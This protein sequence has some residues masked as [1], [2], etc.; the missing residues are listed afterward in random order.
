MKQKK[1]HILLFLGIMIPLFGCKPESRELPKIPIE[2]F[3]RNPLKT[4]FHLSP[5][6]QYIS[7]LKPYKQRLNLFVQKIGSS[8]T[9]QITK[10]VD[11]DIH[12]Y[13]WINKDRIVFLKDKNGDEKYKL[14]VVKVDGTELKQLTP[15]GDTIVFL[16]DILKDRP[17]E[18]L[19]AINER[20]HSVFD[21]YKINII[22]GGKILVAEN[23]GNVTEWLTDHKGKLRIAIST[24]GVNHGIMFRK[25]ED[26]DF[27]LVYA[28]NFKEIL[29]PI[30]F[31]FDNKNVYM[32]SNIKR[33]RIALI[34]YDLE[35]NEELK[36]I[37]E[38]PEVDIEYVDYS[39]KRKVITDI[40]FITWKREYVFFDDDKENLFRKL[41]TKLSG[42][43]I[44]IA[45]MS[46]DE[47][48]ILVKTYSDKSLGSYYF[49]NIENEELIK[50]ADVSP[51]LK[52]E[53]LADMKP[54]WYKSRDGL[55]INGYLTL[56]VKKEAKNLPVV[57]NPHG[58]PWTRDIWGFNNEVQFFANR[59]FAVLQVNYR[60][61][62]GYGLDFMEAGFGEW[63][64]NMQNDITDG[65][66]WL[67]K[68]GIADPNKIG[69]YGFSFGGFC[70]L[71]GAAFTPN[72]YQC[73]ASLSGIADVIN[74]LN[75]IPPYWL[76]FREMLNEMVGDPEKDKEKLVKYSPYYNVDSIKIPLL[77]A[78][79]VN[80]D[81]VDASMV[82]SMVQKLK[83]N[84][85]PVDYILKDNEGHYFRNEENRVEFYQ[86]LEKFLQK[87]L[88]EKSKYLK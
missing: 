19:V 5:D 82:T 84:S 57:I 72:L 48:K 55:T 46:D 25:N 29:A 16:I 58:G 51:W 12:N 2:D 85:V 15:D 53:Y 10:Y 38:H 67:V 6:G 50:L 8:D 79:G 24:D 23:P 64:R 60:G 21:V 30:F 56:P 20:N 52:E 3:F 65:A 13:R 35:K 68:Q 49:F 37:Y 83:K 44:T 33:D 36:T 32:L 42:K 69:I 76:P 66:N 39:K 70:A 54:I 87:H 31:T 59:G 43:E 41:Q 26:E 11:R 74:F 62:S 27:K 80:D 75:T 47:K 17:D 45:S 81:R 14:F 61:S 86:A 63:G 18:I 7:Y 71:A 78:Q 9:V 77:I 40:S 34:E 28:T 4:N 73:A 88:K 1:I 22:N